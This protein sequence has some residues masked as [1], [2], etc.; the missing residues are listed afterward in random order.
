MKKYIA[1]LV[2]AAATLT[3][4]AQINFR[5]GSP[6]LEKE[7]NTIN[8]DAKG[9]IG[10]FKQQLE[11]LHHV[12]IRQIDGLLAKVKEPA[13]AL[14]ALR[15]HSIT[16]TPLDRIMQSY[17]TNRDQGWGKIAK[18]MGIK[19]GSPEFHALKNG[20][21]SGLSGGFTIGKDQS[22]IKYNKKHPDSPIRIDLPGYPIGVS[23]SNG[24]GNSGKGKPQG[25][26]ANGK[27][28]GG[29]GNASH[30]NSNAKGGGNVI[31]GNTKGNGGTSQGNSKAGGGQGNAKSGGGNPGGSKGGGGNGKGKGK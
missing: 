3:S 23:K 21:K 16:N 19:P 10:G 25:N 13:E 28:G 2:V 12:G 4:Y 7:L 18:D 31:Q 1:T 27:Q 30:G 14:L 24:N 5:T 26:S 15:I 8:K 20:K 17:S 11:E 6:E 29:N 9:D 22:V